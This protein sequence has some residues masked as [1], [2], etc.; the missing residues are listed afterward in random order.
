MVA[1]FDDEVL[2][3]GGV[4]VAVGGVIVVFGE[5]IVVFGDDTVVPIVVVVE[6]GEDAVVP[7]V[8]VVVL[9]AATGTANA[10]Y[11]IVLKGFPF[12]PRVILSPAEKVRS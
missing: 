6:G 10:V 11:I 3:F 7:T 8:V 5:V 9:C 12:V 4:V 2:L 1:V